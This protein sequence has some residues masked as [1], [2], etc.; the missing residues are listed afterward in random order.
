MKK[1]LFTL[2]LFF[3]MSLFAAHGPSPEW[4]ILRE[5]E[6]GNTILIDDGS[7]CVIWIDSYADGRW[8]TWYYGCD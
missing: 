4:V 1:L 7:D 3:S 8:K 6:T 5:M 2:S